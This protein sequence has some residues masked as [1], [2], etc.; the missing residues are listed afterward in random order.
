MKKLSNLK[1]K[2]LPGEGSAKENLSVSSSDSGFLDDD[3]DDD[4]D[5]EEEE[6]EEEE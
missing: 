2:K 6:E 5:E 1:A 4:E 3:S